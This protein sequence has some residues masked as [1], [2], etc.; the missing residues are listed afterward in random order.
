MQKY[1]DSKTCQWNN[2]LVYSYIINY[3]V[4]SS[5][6]YFTDNSPLVTIQ[7][8][9]FWQFI[10]RSSGKVKEKPLYQM[11]SDNKTEVSKSDLLFKSHET[12]LPK[13]QLSG[14]TPEAH[15]WRIHNETCD[16]ADY[17]LSIQKLP[18]FHASPYS[19]PRPWF[20]SMSISEKL[21]TET[22]G[23]LQSS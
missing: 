3:I 7:R 8:R 17:L 14:I 22:P 1:K 4:K 10:R 9:D 13:H 5:E 18:L 15:I 6:N 23:T 11:G 12:F 20:F 2:A 21:S 16:S 19:P